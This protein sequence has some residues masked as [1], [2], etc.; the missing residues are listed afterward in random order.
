MV[1]IQLHFA[2]ASDE[3]KEMRRWMIGCAPLSGRNE[4][5]RGRMK[6]IHTNNIWLSW[7]C[8]MRVRFIFLWFCAGNW[9]RFLSWFQLRCRSGRGSRLAFWWRLG[10]LLRMRQWTWIAQRFPAAHICWLQSHLSAEWLLSVSPLPYTIHQTN[11]VAFLPVL[12]ILG[13]RLQSRW[14]QFRFRWC[15]SA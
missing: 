1:P 9:I 4:M 13:F 14:R 8:G 6:C 5:M 10:W 7:N 2:L 15:L 12:L 3:R 11:L